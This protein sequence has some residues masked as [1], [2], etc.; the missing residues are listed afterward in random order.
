MAAAK[1]EILLSQRRGELATK[2]MAWQR[3]AV[4]MDRRG[5][6]AAKHRP[7]KLL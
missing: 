7:P 1:P 3:A 5:P 2:F 4:T 6:A